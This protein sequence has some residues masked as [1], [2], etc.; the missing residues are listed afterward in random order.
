MEHHDLAKPREKENF[1]YLACRS[2]QFCNWFSQFSRNV[3][4]EPFRNN[5]GFLVFHFLVSVQF[6][7]QFRDLGVPKF[8]DLTEITLNLVVIFGNFGELAHKNLSIVSFLARQNPSIGKFWACFAVKV[9][10]VARYPRPHRFG[11]DKI[12]RSATFGWFT[13]VLHG[14][15]AARSG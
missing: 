3:R 12:A 13:N 8:G 14:P 2:Y 11:H 7:T 4:L 1:G 6:P 5:F 10:C 9:K 15:Q